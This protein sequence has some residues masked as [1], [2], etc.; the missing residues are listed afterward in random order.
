M[1]SLAAVEPARPDE[2]ADALRLL[3]RDI[4]DPERERR[5][6]SAL[7]LLRTGELDPAGLFV[8]RDVNGLTGVLICLPVPGASALFWP[9]RSVADSDPIARE[10][11]LLARGLLWVRGRGAKLS[12]SLLTVEEVALAG[13]LLRNG[14]RHVTRLWY[15]AVEVNG[16]VAQQS[17]SS[18]LEYHSYGPEKAST[19]HATLLRTYEG[20][21]DCPEISG[22]RNVEEV[23]EGHQAQGRFNP[24]RWWLALEAGRPAGV[25]LTTE[26]PQTGDWDVSYLGIT[27]DLR[28][29]GFG[30]EVM[31]KALQEARMA[32]I[33]RLTLS[34]D[35][36]NGPALHLYR[37]L[38]FVPY[39]CREV[40]LAIW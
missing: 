8:E 12:Q 6:T 1:Q 24:A 18:S 26:M 13:S 29:R 39:D 40:Y 4:P 22:L 3:F 34:V 10:D 27:P 23:I 36:R 5:I 17:S 28:R 7:D 37:N 25:L 11:R 19:F 20:T 30:R 21:L 32:G 35:A 38:G 31:N 16:P 15:L 33:N 9:P 2:Q 14:F